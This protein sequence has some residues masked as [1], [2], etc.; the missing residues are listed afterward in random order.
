MITFKTLIKIIFCALLPG[1]LPGGPIDSLVQGAR[2]PKVT[3]PM[4]F[5]NNACSTKTGVT[6]VVGP[7]V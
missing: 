4:K 3:Y 1:S 6:G 2:K 5:T 7:L